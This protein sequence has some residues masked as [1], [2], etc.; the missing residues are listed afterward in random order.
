MTGASGWRPH[1]R[2]G[3]GEIPADAAPGPVLPRCDDVRAI[4]GPGLE[5]VDA[6][7]PPVP[8]R[9]PQRAVLRAQRPR[10]ARAASTP[11]H[12]AR[13]QQPRRDVRR[14]SP[15]VRPVPAAARRTAARGRHRGERHRLQP[16]RRRRPRA[17]LRRR[18]H[19]DRPQR[20]RPGRGRTLACSTAVPSCPPHRVRGRTGRVRQRL[21]PADPCLQPDAASQRLTTRRRR[22]RIATPPPSGARRRP[23]SR[24]A[25]GVPRPPHRGRGRGG[26]GCCG[27]RGR[28]QPDG[29][30]RH[31]CSRA[32]R[33][34]RPLVASRRGGPGSLVTD[35]VDGVLVDPDDTASFASALTRVVQDPELAA[36]LGVPA[37]R[38]CAGSAGIGW[39]SSTSGC[40][41]A[42]SLA[43]QATPT[44]GRAPR[45]CVPR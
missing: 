15:G 45:R 4:V 41:G 20:D 43:K 12:A 10:R 24:L 34:C 18:R 27:C 25:R 21:P 33:S 19:R 11:R 28:P 16:G 7:P 9:R 30:L 8:A 17:A 26:D 22:R 6:R 32:W 2:P 13:H 35:G 14:R 3:D 42:R 44:R 37:A 5:P 1:R 29:G 39:S 38:P 36:R 23:G 40:T 31:R